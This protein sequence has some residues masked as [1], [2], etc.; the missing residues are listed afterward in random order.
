MMHRPK[1]GIRRAHMPQHARN[2]T[3]DANQR[4]RQWHNR[5]QHLR[6]KSPL[7][8][9]KIIIPGIDKTLVLAA[10]W[11]FIDHFF[12]IRLR[13]WAEADEPDSLRAVM[14]AIDAIVI[15]DLRTI[16]DDGGPAFVVLLLLVRDWFNLAVGNGA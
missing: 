2:H 7:Q 8:H 9:C 16:A 10:L 13:V 14:P 11:I 1:P 15:L 4:Q 3:D 6:L 12:R 5:N